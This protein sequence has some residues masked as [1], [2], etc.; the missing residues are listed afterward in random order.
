MWVVIL[1]YAARGIIAFAEA[2]PELLEQVVHL[3][4]AKLATRG[5]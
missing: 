1:R 5:K 3:I 2:H 4:A